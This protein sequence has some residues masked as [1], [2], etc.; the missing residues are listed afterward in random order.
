M[1]AGDVL[2]QWDVR[3]GTA[4]QYF[5]RALQLDPTN[6]YAIDR[7]IDSAW[8]AGQSAQFLPLI[9][10]A[11]A[12]ARY[13]ETRLQGS[14]TAGSINGELQTVAVALL[15]AGKEREGIELLD[16]DAR[17]RGTPG[18]RGILWNTY[19]CYQGRMAEAEAEVRSVFDRFESIDDNPLLMGKKPPYYELH[20]VLLASGRVR[21]AHAAWDGRGT[22]PAWPPWAGRDFAIVRG[23]AEELHAAAV[24]WLEANDAD[25]QRN[26]FMAWYFAILGDRSRA[27]ER[28]LT[29]K[30]TQD[31]TTTANEGHRRNGEAILAWS[32]GRTD[33]ADRLMAEHGKDSLAWLFYNHLLA[34]SLHFTAGE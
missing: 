34:G 11:A 14:A 3:L 30:S 31:W 13:D 16:R 26:S 22:K 4:A 24:L 19:L 2:V 29:A 18:S 6:I 27:R 15:A 17:V 10:R 33:E 25:W 5:E 1:Q 7:L 32:E 23:S 20:H 9:G 28:I 21:E 12:A 8:W